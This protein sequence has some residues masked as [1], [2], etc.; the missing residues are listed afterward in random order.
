MAGGE[1]VD[2]GSSTWNSG[3]TEAA[4]G[5]FSDHGESIY[6]FLTTGRTR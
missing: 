2:G 6:G 5:S 3:E 1:H 4:N